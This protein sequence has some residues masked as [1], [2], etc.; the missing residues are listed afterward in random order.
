[1]IVK[2]LLSIVTSARN[3]NYMGN[4]QWRLETT[5]NFIAA[6]LKKINRLNDVEFVIT[7]WCS[8]I[9][10]RTVLSLNQE[11]QKI[12]RFIIVSPA[13][14]GKIKTDSDFPA[15]TSFNVAVRRARGRFICLTCTDILWSKNFL[16]SFFDILEGNIKIGG[17]VK[18]SLC[19][20][21]R[22]KI[23]AGTIN[24]KPSVADL[25]KFIEDQDDN[26]EV[27]FLHPYLLAPAGS[28]MMSRELWFECRGLNEKLNKWGWNDIDLALR[29]RLRNYSCLDM[30]KRYDMHTYHLEHPASLTGKEPNP[31]IFSPFI[32]NDK[33][34]GFA[35]YRF[36][37]FP[38]AEPLNVS[39]NLEKKPHK[40]DKWFT[41]KHLLNL[42][43]FF[44]KNISLSNLK[45]TFDYFLLIIK[46]CPDKRIEKRIYLCLKSIKNQLKQKMVNHS[47]DQENRK[48]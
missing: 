21:S 28:W 40:T 18:K 38:P 10:L 5:I 44:L 7:D 17:G 14:I 46:Q 3:D 41:E 29:M 34:W 32:V 23:P 15:S 1:M 31:Q 24:K 22:K 8:D 11:A 37:E 47:D 35:N 33:N 19:V 42:I 36:E 6:N 4:F 27:E 13:A 25:E 20:F 16:I 9:P 2:P 12:T 26:I 39:D 30:G 43:V 45:W 48:E